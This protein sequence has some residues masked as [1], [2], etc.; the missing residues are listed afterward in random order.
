MQLLLSV[1]GDNSAM[2]DR[3]VDLVVKQESRYF[4]RALER[5]IDTFEVTSVPLKQLIIN[6]K[7]GVFADIILN[8]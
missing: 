6:I 7:K 8:F 2:I 3:V 4:L 5:N 1:V